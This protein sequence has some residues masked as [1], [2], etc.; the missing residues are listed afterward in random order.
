MK[1]SSLYY[2]DTRT[3][4]KLRV[5]VEI[6]LDDDCRN[7]HNDFSITGTVFEKNFLDIWTDTCC[8]CCHDEILKV[9]PEFQPFVDL[10]L[11]DAKGAPMYAEANGFYFLEQKD[12]QDVAKSYLRLTEPEYEQIKATASDQ[13][14][15]KY[16][17]Y[18]MGIVARWERE[19]K[20]AIKLLEEMTGKMFEDDSRRYQLA[21]LTPE[22]AELIERRMS[23]GYYQHEAI[24]RRRIQAVEDKRLK[25]I[26]NL[27]E[28]AA[29]DIRKIETILA[30]KI[31]V[32]ETGMTL[33]EFI[34]YDHTNTGVFNWHTGYRIN[35]KVTPEEFEVFLARVDYSKLPEGIK[36]ILK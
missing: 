16:L 24:E 34:Y 28:G 36:F 14:C 29:K 3:K 5:H 12:K 33:D 2:E 4:G 25:T 31:Q 11:C 27:R 19:A 18:D 17:L 9:F 23:E 1:T 8:G 7:G 22:E 6:R 21:P 35:E 32:L 30:V 20:A 10:H 13:L 26:H 15:L